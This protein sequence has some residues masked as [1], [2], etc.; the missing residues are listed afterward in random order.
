MKALRS[1]LVS[2][3][4]SE[5]ELKTETENVVNAILSKSKAVIALGKQFFYSQIN[6]NLETAYNNGSRVMVENLCLTDGQEGINAFIA[7]RVPH[8]THSTDRIE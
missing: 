2:R 5:Q 6:Q 3:V 1:G 7:K 8:W 4:V